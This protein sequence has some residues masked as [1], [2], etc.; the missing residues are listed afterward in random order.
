MLA[1][2]K[3]ELKAY[4]SSLLG[5]AVITLFLLVLGFYFWGINLSGQNGAIG[6]TLN[7]ISF[8]YTIILPILTMRLFAE[9]QKLKTD[10]L[11]FSSPVS[12]WSVILGKY[13][14]VVTIF[15]IPNLVICSMPLV[16]SK[17]G[18]VVMLKSYSSIFAFWLLGCTMLALGVFASSLTDNQFVAVLFSFAMN[19]VIL[20][21]QSIASIVP[22]TTMASLIGVSIIALLVCAVIFLFVRNIIVSGAVFVVA[23]AAIVVLYLVKE[24]WFESLLEKILNAVSFYARFTDFANG[25]FNVGSVIYYLSFIVLFLYFTMQAIQKRRWS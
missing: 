20:L 16:L 7:S 25:N 23:E 14:A 12:I 13:F 19:I 2:Y 6:N 3:R 9:E 24:S 8:V 5:Y 11:L 21:M 17:Y 1:I 10:Q 22:S 4:F 18:D 15:T